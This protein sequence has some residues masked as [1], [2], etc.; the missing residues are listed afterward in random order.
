ML[1]TEY[2]LSFVKD[3]NDYEDTDIFDSKLK[4]L[5]SASMGRMQAEGIPNIFDEDTDEGNMYCSCVALRCEIDNNRD[6]DCTMLRSLLLSDEIILREWATLKQ[7][8]DTDI[9]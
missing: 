6:A 4:R 1:G 8:S 2:V 7:S 5:I 9:S 3:Y